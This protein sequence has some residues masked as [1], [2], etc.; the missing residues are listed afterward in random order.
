[1]TVGIRKDRMV[2]A[3]HALGICDEA[4]YAFLRGRSTIQPAMIKKLLLERAKHQAVM[5]WF[6]ATIKD[7]STH[8]VRHPDGEGGEVSVEA[9]I[10]ADY[11]SAYQSDIAW[12]RCDA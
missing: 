1:M 10:F 4:Q 9:T 12:P 2:Q 11:A 3:W 6:L 8:P 5:D 7:A